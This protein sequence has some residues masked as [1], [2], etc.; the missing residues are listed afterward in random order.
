MIN[1]EERTKA[2]LTDAEFIKHYFPNFIHVKTFVP[3]ESFGEI[4]LLT[5]QG[6]YKR[7]I[8]ESYNNYIFLISHSPFSILIKRTAT[9]VSKENSEF[10]V[11]EKEGFE[12]AMASMKKNVITEK[13]E[14]IKSFDFF[15]NISIR[16]VL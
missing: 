1:E 2:N 8:K 13:I 9:L 16:K 11:L 5:S 3:G 7:N 6:R 10:M 15:S 4:A 14:F 12:K